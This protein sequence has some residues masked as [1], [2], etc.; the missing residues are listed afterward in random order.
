M[1]FYFWSPVSENVPD[2]L[3]A[4]L[5]QQMARH[6]KLVAVYLGFT[7]D[8]VSTFDSENHVVSEKVIAMLSEWKHQQAKNATR[9]NLMKALVKAE[10]KDLADKVCI[11]R[12]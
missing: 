5:S 4:D 12:E 3:L 2:T 11:Y 1:G 10:R 7:P 9:S 6:W 8:H